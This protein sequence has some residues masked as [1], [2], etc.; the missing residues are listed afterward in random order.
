MVE[1]YRLEQRLEP[2][3]PE[4]GGYRIWYPGADGLAYIG[5]TAAFAD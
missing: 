1:P 2:E 5:E 4:S 3:L